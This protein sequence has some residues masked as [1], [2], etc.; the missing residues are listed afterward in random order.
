MENFK[1]ID[2]KKQKRQYRKRK[3]SASSR[4]EGE[5]T[6]SSS[7][8]SSSS[9]S[10]SEE[11]PKERFK[12]T[13]IEKKREKTPEKRKRSVSR[14][15]E[16]IESISKPVEEATDSKKD[17]GESSLENDKVKNEPVPE[18]QSPLKEV[19]PTINIWQ[20]RTV[21]AAFDEALKRYMER[22]SKRQGSY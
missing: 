2:S 8:S 18:I 14:G 1:Q 21:G 6:S 15:K 19:K 22:K 16:N 11:E 17:K 9:S 12:K 7:Y 3:R 4:E 5:K 10:E 13:E 20:K